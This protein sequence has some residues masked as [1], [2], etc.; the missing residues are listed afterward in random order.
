[1]KHDF[2]WCQFAD[3]FM[4]TIICGLSLMILAIAIIY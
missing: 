4:Q 1:M 3:D 2:D